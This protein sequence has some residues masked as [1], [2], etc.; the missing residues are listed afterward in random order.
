MAEDPFADLAKTDY[1]GLRDEADTF[2]D[3]NVLRFFYDLDSQHRHGNGYFFQSAITVA[4]PSP[5][6]ITGGDP[7]YPKGHR[8]LGSG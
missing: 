4:V 2:A 8:K 3:F 5:K 7:I 1:A 6:R